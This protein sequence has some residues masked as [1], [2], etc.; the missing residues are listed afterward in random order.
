MRHRPLRVRL[1]V[2][3]TLSMALSLVLFGVVVYLRMGWTLN[4]A[5]DEDLEH[6]FYSIAGILAAE[7]AEGVRVH[8]ALLGGFREELAQVLGVDG[9]VLESPEGLTV[10]LISMETASGLLAGNLSEKLTVPGEPHPVRVLAGSVDAPQGKLILVVARSL[11]D[12]NEAQ[13]RILQELA[14][15]LPVILVLSSLLAYLLARGALRPVEA[16]RSRAASIETSDLGVRLPVPP[17][18]DEIARLGATLN[19]MLDRLEVS[20]QRERAFVA[21]ASHELRTPLSLLKIELE[22]ALRRPRSPEEMRRAVESAA[23]DTDGLV[24]LA[25]DLLVL[26]R[27]DQGQLQIRRTSLPVAATLLSAVEGFRARAERQ[28]RRITVAQTAAE[29]EIYADRARLEQVLRNLLENAL[30]HGGG[31]I[32]V[33]AEEIEGEIR[34][35]VKDKGPGF[36]PSFLPR[37]F[38]RFARADTS[39]SGEG[40][41]LGLSIVRAIAEAHGG[42]AGADNRAGGGADVWVAIPSSSH[43]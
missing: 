18:H 41:G 14:L 10:P 22:L 34:L 17:S 42:R 4:Q 21:D 7:G 8:P 26:A 11:N 27:A 19:E 32:E 15:G 30:C 16:M 39:R 36:A 40:V 9:R 1:T 12:R 20:I 2:L 35:H 25:D 13:L 38:H 5:Y 29:L 24:E 23:E 33:Q 28:E 37:A 6:Q 31:D 43:D 3:F